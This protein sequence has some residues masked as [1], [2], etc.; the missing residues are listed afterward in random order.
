ML[1]SVLIIL[2]QMCFLFF[3]SQVH[4]S[5]FV[6]HKRTKN[7]FPSVRLGHATI[8]IEVKWQDTLFLCVSVCF[9]VKI[10]KAQ[11]SLFL[12]GVQIVNTPNNLFVC[13]F[14]IVKGEDT[15]SCVFLEIV[16]APD[17]FFLCLLRYCCQSTRH[18]FPMC[19]LRYSEQRHPFLCICWDT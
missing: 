10:V 6:T 3:P 15:L 14:E 19:L 13:V 4:Q 2:A 18:P 1:V 7:T 11:D 16:K 17:T 5:L 9:F 8:W 12:C